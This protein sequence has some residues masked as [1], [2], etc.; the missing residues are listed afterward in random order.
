M[1]CAICAHAENGEKPEHKRFKNWSGLSSSTETNIL[2]EGFCQA[3]QQHGVPWH[4][5][6]HTVGIPSPCPCSS[7]HLTS[8]LSLPPPIVDD[9]KPGPSSVTL[10]PSDSPQSANELPEIA[11][12]C[13]S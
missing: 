1:Y 3:E 6:P 9:C 5:D 7:N 11:L 13:R 12:S 4:Q 10:R 8:P 2:L